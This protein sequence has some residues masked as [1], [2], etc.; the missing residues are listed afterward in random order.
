[1]SLYSMWEY[2]KTKPLNP[3]RVLSRNPHNPLGIL[4]DFLVCM[5]AMRFSRQARGPH[6]DQKR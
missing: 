2:T 1:M 3:F 4:A 5:L 6:S